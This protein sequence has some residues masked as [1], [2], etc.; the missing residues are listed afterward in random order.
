ME[1]EQD[2][3]SA[4]VCCRHGHAIPGAE[5]PRQPRAC[6]PNKIADCPQRML[7]GQPGRPEAGWLRHQPKRAHRHCHQ[8]QGHPQRAMHQLHGVRL[9]HHPIEAKHNAFTGCTNA[10]LVP[11]WWV[12]SVPDEAEANMTWSFIQWETGLKIPCLCNTCLL[13]HQPDQAGP[14]AKKAKK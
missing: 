2:A 6:H 11:A 5:P 9:V 14:A 8:M 13:V 12:K 3:A 4:A 10:S 1:G 7:H